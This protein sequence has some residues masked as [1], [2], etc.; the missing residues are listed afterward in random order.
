MNQAWLLALK[1]RA[2][3]QRWSRKLPHNRVRRPRI[4][5]E[6]GQTIGYGPR[7]PVPE[8]ELSTVFCQKVQLPSGRVDVVLAETGISAA[9]RQSRYPKPTEAEV[10]PLPISEEEVRAL[11]ARHG[12]N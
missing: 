9:Y 12:C 5:N 8:P 7:V 1:E 10:E 4:R 11:C 2:A 6:R 3:W